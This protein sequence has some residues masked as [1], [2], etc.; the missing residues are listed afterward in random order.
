MQRRIKIFM[1][2]AVVALASVSAVFF[3]AFSQSGGNE[4]KAG[5]TLRSGQSSYN[6]NFRG[7]DGYGSSWYQC[8]SAYNPR[9]DQ[10]PVCGYVPYGRSLMTIAKYGYC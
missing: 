10:G 1:L 5:T 6:C 7:G 2:V 3:G 4:A 9:G 8:T